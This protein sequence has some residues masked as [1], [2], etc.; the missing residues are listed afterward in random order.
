MDYPRTLYRISLVT[1][2][3]PALLVHNETEHRAARAVGW[4]DSIPEALADAESE[5]DT[6]EEAE[7][8][9]PP[10]REEMESKARELGISFNKRTSDAKLL[11]RIEKALFGG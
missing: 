2:V 6:L 8:L 9:L 5:P 1:S 7:D 10:T 3:Y 4:R 11:E